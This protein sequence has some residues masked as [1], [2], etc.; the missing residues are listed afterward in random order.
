MRTRM[1][2]LLR[3]VMFLLIAGSIAGYP[4]IHASSATT[5]SWKPVADT[6]VRSNSITTN[7]GTWTILRVDGSPLVHSYLRFTVSGIN[8][9]S[10][11]KLRIYAKTA[12][13][14]G[15][16][17]SQVA[18]NT[19]SEKG[20]TWAN[21]PAFGT[22]FGTSTAIK[23][24]TWIT[25]DVSSYVKGNGMYSFGLS[26]PGSTDVSLA[27]RETGTY[28]PQLVITSGEVSNP[29]PPTEVATQAPTISPTST[30]N[31]PISFDDGF[32][33]SPLN[34]S[35]WNTTYGSGGGGEQ[36]YYSS[37]A[38][39]TAYSILYMSASKTPA[40]G[41]PYTSGI[42]HTKGK[43]AQLYGGFEIKARIPKGKGFWPAFW[44]LPATPD[45]PV[46]IDVFENLGKDTHTIYLSNHYKGTDGSNQHTT[47]TYHTLVDLSADFHTYALDWTSTRLTWYLDGNELYTTTQNIPHEPMF[48]IANLAVG[49]TWGG[50]PDSTTVFPG[51]MQIQ[52]VRAYTQACQ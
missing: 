12:S 49:G 19:W 25:F 42:I 6:F 8:S 15:L 30:C 22:S 46:E 33:S 20:L 11:A 45:F 21:A 51:I 32:N 28:S 14:S 3:V 41:Y 44:L 47:I 48:M 9:V 36:Q 18:D 7:T 10:S 4:L 1:K 17:V 23:A 16:T 50:Y 24:A 27:A 13:P 35:L 29:I 34:T 37:G 26:T 31:S 43:Y 5:T 2:G 39:K 40:N 52:Y 38:L